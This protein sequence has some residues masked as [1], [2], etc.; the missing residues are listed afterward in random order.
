[1]HFRRLRV[2]A[3]FPCK[4]SQNFAVGIFK[5]RDA[6]FRRGANVWHRGIRALFLL[7]Q[8][9]VAR[10]FLLPPAGQVGRQTSAHGLSCEF[11]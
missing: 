10:A 4:I 6:E 1:M 9:S 3:K 11:V 7:V 8:V 2:Y 5:Y